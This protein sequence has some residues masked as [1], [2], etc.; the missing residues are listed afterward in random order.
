V[1]ALLEI[2]KVAGHDRK[3][4]RLLIVYTNETFQKEKSVSVVLCGREAAT[5]RPSLLPPLT[6]PQHPYMIFFF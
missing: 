6:P 5:N 3:I 1:L 2:A 4:I